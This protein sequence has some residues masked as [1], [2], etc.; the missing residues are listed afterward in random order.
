[1]PLTSAAHASGMR[2]TA[3]CLSLATLPGLLCVPDADALEGDMGE[4]HA[5]LSGSL[6]VGAI[7]RAESSDQDFL[8]QGNAEAADSGASGYNPTGARNIDDGRAN[9]ADRELASTPVILATQLDLDYRNVG[10]RIAGKAWYDIHQQHHHVPHKQ[11]TGGL[12]RFFKNI[13]FKICFKTY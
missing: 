2:R 12:H 6:S 1:M 8:F 11:H 10:A 13:F 3:L 9:Y 4:I 7:W 5:K